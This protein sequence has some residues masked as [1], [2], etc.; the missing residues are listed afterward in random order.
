MPTRRAIPTAR[1]LHEW[2]EPASTVAARLLDEPGP[3]DWAVSVLWRAAAESSRAGEFDRASALLRRALRAMPPTIDRERVRTVIEL[4]RIEAASGHD[5]ARGRWETAADQLRELDPS[6]RVSA[7]VD[8]GEATYSA[9]LLT[10]ARAHF[11]QAY[12]LCDEH[13]DPPLVD[14]ETAARMIAGLSTASLLTGH[15]HRGAESRLRSIVRSTPRYPDLPTRAL[16]ASA[17]GEVALGV[18]L[19]AELVHRLIDGALGDEPLPPDVLRPVFEPLSAALSLTGRPDAAVELLDARLEIARSRNDLISHVSLLP[20][21]A[22]AHL[23][24]DRLERARNDAL[25]AIELIEAHPG[26]TRLAEAPARYALSTALVELDELEEAATVCD[27]PDH[28]QRWGS[29]PMHGWF[30]DGLARVRSSQHRHEDAMGAWRDAARSFTLVGGGGVICE[31][32]DG[33]ARSL[34]AIGDRPAAQQLAAEHVAVATAFGD[35]RIRA[36]AEGTAA[37]ADADHLAAADRL[38]A[39]IAVLPSGS[40]EL[41]RCRLGFER[42]ARL[43]RAGL[44]RSARD[45]L[46]ASLAIA[47]RLGAR[48]LA[49]LIDDELI[50]AGASRSRSAGPGQGHVLTPT[51]RR[52]AEM[53]ASGLGNVEIARR[54]SVSRKTVESQ[55]SSVYR[56]LGIDDRSQLRCALTPESAGT[57]V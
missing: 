46:A 21:R 38:G 48:R 41:T 40:A 18:D 34:V 16:M 32:R 45:Q 30:L 10:D 24:A 1:E 3:A 4:G 22:H 42:G 47:S 43:R 35:A 36:I 8:L 39:A 50:A 25:D 2:G 19:P 9:G 51:E 28:R 14:D 52:T 20:L 49:R 37:A 12:Q 29:T 15:R 44:R 7:L 26:A 23:L 17:A 57:T 11:E 5:G 33:L 31:W 13:C 27:V 53:A 54:R 55:L 6:D 56:K